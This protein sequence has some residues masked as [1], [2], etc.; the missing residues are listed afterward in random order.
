MKI[1][2]QKDEDIF[3][4]YGDEEAEFYMKMEKLEEEKRKTQKVNREEVK[5]E[6]GDKQGR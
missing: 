5:V 3:I 1:Y 4:K 6:R 2:L